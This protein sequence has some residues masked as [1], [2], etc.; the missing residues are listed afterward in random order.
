MGDGFWYISRTVTFV[1]LVFFNDKLTPTAFEQPLSSAHS[2]AA[3]SVAHPLLVLSTNFVCS[4]Y[5]H[6]TRGNSVGNLQTDTA[7]SAVLCETYSQCGV[8]DDTS[9]LGWQRVYWHLPTFHGTLLPPHLVSEKV[10]K[11]G[12]SIPMYTLPYPRSFKTSSTVFTLLLKTK[13]RR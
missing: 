9:S 5:N 2:G 12:K 11:V 4:W 10:E 1:F 8:D 6:Y 3:N 13:H 7:T